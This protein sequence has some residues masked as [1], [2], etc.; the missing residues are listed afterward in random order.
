MKKKAI[1]ALVIIVISL[2]A[3]LFTFPSQA[4]VPPASVTPTSTIGGS[5]HN[6]NIAYCSTEGLGWIFCRLMDIATAA[7]DSAYSLLHNMLRINPELISDE[8]KP[9]QGGEDNKSAIYKIWENFRNISNVL[10]VIVVLIIILSYVTGFGLNNYQIKKMLPKIIV[11]AILINL[12]FIITQVAVDISNIVGNSIGEFFDNVASLESEPTDPLAVGASGAGIDLALTV[13][14]ILTVA[15]AGSLV[16]FLLP[17]VFFIMTIILTALVLMYLRQAAVIMIAVLSP[18]AFASM[19]LPGT[20]KIFDTWKT[21]LL[22]VILLYPIM[23][24]LFSSSRLAGDIIVAAADKDSLLIFLG[25]ILPVIPLVLV[26]SILKNAVSKIP[27]AGSIATNTLGKLQGW[28]DKKARNST[29]SRYSA[30]RWQKKKQNRQIRA[31]SPNATIGDKILAPGSW[32][33]SH[34][35]SGRARLHEAEL[36]QDKDIQSMAGQLKDEDVASIEKA[37]LINNEP[38]R[39]EALTQSAR[40]ILAASGGD[41]GK[42]YMS[43]RENLSN[44][45]DADPTRSAKLTE[46]AL[47]AGMSNQ[48]VMR[49]NKRC[50]ENSIKAN[51]VAAAAAYRGANDGSRANL[52]TATH[53]LSDSYRNYLQNV[54]PNTLGGASSESLR[55][56]GDELKDLY[57]SNEYFKSNVDNILGGQFNSASSAKST[58]NDI[59]K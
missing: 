25:T 6:L 31:A 32:L 39:Q 44:Q 53:K 27:M 28:G 26:P 59:I 57:G 11:A 48:Q 13:G 23:A 24:L 37:M 33:G 5:V 58:I 47:K 55:L 51:N 29:F 56:V 2:T 34:T 21:T 10:I 8:A 38:D 7:S 46:S 4:T 43:A 35:K 41:Y 36:Q 18:I 15:N 22:T 40:D 45:S 12:S 9:G 3:T 20:K 42:L 1:S 52:E 16:P 49:N 14:V 17:T 19:L 30:L 54:N 50:E